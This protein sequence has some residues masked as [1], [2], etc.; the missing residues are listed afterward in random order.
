MAMK[1][2]TLIVNSLFI[3]KKIMNLEYKTAT[4]RILPIIFSF[5]LAYLMFLIRDIPILRIALM[6]L[7]LG[8]FNSL[9][10]KTKIDLAITTTIIA[11]GMSYAF[12]YIAALLAAFSQQV[13]FQS[14]NINV[15]ATITFIVTPLISSIPFLFKRTRRGF[16]FLQK[17]EAGGI[18]LLIS[19][20]IIIFA[21]LMSIR[22]MND[23]V[24]GALLLGL[25]ICIA[26]IILWWRKSLTEMYK[27]KLKEQDMKELEAVIDEKDKQIQKLSERN[28]FLAEVIHRDNKLIPAMYNTVQTYMNA[29]NSGKLKEDGNAILNQ[30]HQ[31]MQERAGIILQDQKEHKILPPT[32]L[33]LLDSILNF[34]CQKSTENNVEFD[35]RITGNI[36]HMAETVIP[37]LKIETL[38]ADLVENAIISVSGCQYKRILVTMGVAGDFYE[39]R[40]QDSGIPFEAQTLMNLGEK[41]VTSHEKSGGSGIGYMTLF[42]IIRETGASLIITENPSKPYSFTKAVTIRFDGKNEYTVISYRRDELN[43]LCKRE[44]L[45]VLAL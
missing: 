4:K 42:K 41:K 30:L 3:Y 11:T 44:D 12:F 5:G 15:L 2:F 37:E 31:V 26:G 7:I 39:L 13:L 6:V 38:I 36:K 19:G 29:D 45:T 43:L 1:Y 27:E 8:I 32:K 16:L 22:D 24:F 34:M 20:I 14:E 21:A 9:L 10:M 33:D 35:L 28:D 18:G 25:L 17:K 23:Y 40:V